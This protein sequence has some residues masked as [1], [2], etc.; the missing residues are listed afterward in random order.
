MISSLVS[1]LFRTTFL[2]FKIFVTGI[3]LNFKLQRTYLAWYLSLMFAEI[4]VM[5]PGCAQFL[6]MFR[7]CSKRLCIRQLLRLCMRS[8]LLTTLLRSI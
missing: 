7:V 2:N 8:I 3:Q 6:E 4:C 1:V 5:K